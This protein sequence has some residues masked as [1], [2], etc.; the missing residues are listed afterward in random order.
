MAGTGY[1]MPAEL[2]VTGAVQLVVVTLP[3]DPVGPFGMQAEH[4][5]EKPGVPIPE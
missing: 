1:R 2:Q 4:E 5:P 3:T